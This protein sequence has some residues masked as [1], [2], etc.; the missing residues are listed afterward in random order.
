MRTTDRGD[1]PGTA[2][3]PRCQGKQEAI[4]DAALTLLAEQG[5]T[6]MTRHQVART[7]A[8]GKA[9][10][11]LRFRTK[12]GPAAAAPAALR[13]CAAPGPAGDPQG[14]PRARPAGLAAG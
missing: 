10:V 3:R 9:T 14:D 2:G 13:P 5:F 6:R 11:H 4:L 12:A 7:V 1:C 8:V